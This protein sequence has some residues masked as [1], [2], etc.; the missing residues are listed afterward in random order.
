[1][2]PTKEPQTFD[3]V[4]EIEKR[5]YYVLTQEPKALTGHRSA[6]AVGIL[7]QRLHAKGVLKKKDIDAILLECAY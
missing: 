7:F 4:E 3:D 2:P 5:V 1:M 6:K